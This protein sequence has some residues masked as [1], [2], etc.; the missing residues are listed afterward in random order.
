MNDKL[1]PVVVKLAKRLVGHF[2]LRL[3]FVLEASESAI[4][5]ACFWL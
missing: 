3:L 5:L 2:F 4:A 1:R